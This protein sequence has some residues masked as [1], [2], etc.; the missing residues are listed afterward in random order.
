MM[1]LLR[2]ALQLVLFFLLLSLVVAVASAQ[3][4]TVEKVALIAAGALLV[5]VASRV[6]RIGA[7]VHLA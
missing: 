7:P 2:L 5:W 6:R 4:G 1:R 3:T